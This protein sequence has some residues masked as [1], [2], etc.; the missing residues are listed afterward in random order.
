M[1]IATG[2]EIP[3]ADHPMMTSTVRIIMSDKFNLITFYP[4]WQMLYEQHLQFA[5]V[6]PLVVLG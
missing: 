6:L 5:F 1:E 2:R 3:D 4:T